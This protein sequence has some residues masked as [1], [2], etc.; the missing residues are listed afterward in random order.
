MT[1]MKLVHR[2]VEDA[3]EGRASRAEGA[4][5]KAGAHQADVAGGYG[6][7]RRTVSGFVPVVRMPLA[8]AAGAEDDD[9][10]EQ[11]FCSW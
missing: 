11:G 2:D 5:M 4:E 10:L 3:S 7:G 1:T 8:K 6:T 9:W